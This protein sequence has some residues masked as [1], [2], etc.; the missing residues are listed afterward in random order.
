VS[1]NSLNVLTP[2]LL[3]NLSDIEYLIFN[4]MSEMISIYDTELRIQWANS[5]V[6]KSVNLDLDSIIGHYYFDIWK[7][8]KIHHGNYSLLE[9]IKTGKPQHTKII[10][11]HGQVLQIIVYPLFDDLSKIIGLLEFREDITERTRVEELHAN[12][13]ENRITE[14]QLMESEEKFRDLVEYS[15]EPIMIIN[16]QGTIL[17]ENHAIVN[18]IELEEDS[19][20]IG[21]NVIEF[22]ALEFQNVFIRDF[23][24]VSKEIDGVVSEYQFETAKRNRIYVE[25]VGKCI[26]YDGQSAKLISIHN[27]TTRIKDEEEL[28]KQNEMINRAYHELTEIEEDMRNSYREIVVKGQKLRESEERFRAIFSIVPDPIILT[29]IIDGKIVDCNPALVKLLNIPYENILGKSTIDFCIWNSQKEREKFLAEI[30]RNGVYDKREILWQ[31]NGG[32]FLNIIFSSA[33]VEIN[34]EKVILSVGFDYTNLKKAQDSL[35]ESEEMFR[36]PVENSPVGIFLFQDGFL[37]YSNKRLATM[38]GYSRDDLL[39]IPVE[40]LFSASDIQRI[41]DN[42]DK[43]ENNQPYEVRIE[44]QYAK[45]DGYSLELELYASRMQ[46]RGHPAL[47]GTI[48][49]I[50]NKKLTEKLRLAS[51]SKYRLIA[52]NMK[53]VIWILDIET[54]YFKYISPSIKHLLGYSA[55]EIEG[56]PFSDLLKPDTYNH[57]KEKFHIQLEKFLLYPYKTKFYLTKLEQQSKDGSTVLTEVV[58]NFFLNEETQKVELLGVSRDISEREKDEREIEQK[59][60]ELYRKNEE[61]YSKNE[62]LAKNQIALKFSEESLKKAQAIAHLAVWEWDV[63]NNQVYV[64]DEFNKILGRNSTESPPFYSY[65]LNSIEPQY[66]DQFDKAIKSLFE[67]GIPFT[68]DFWMIREDDGT[69]R[70]IRGQGEYNFVNEESELLT[71][72][73]QDITDQKKMEDEIREAALEKEILLR[74][75]HHRV[76]NNMQVISSLLSMQSRTIK[77]SHIQ[78]MFKETQTRVRSLA[79][80]HEFLYQSNKLDKINYNDYLHKISSYLLDLYEKP[81]G[82]L[83]LIINANNIE[84]SI[85]KA[86]PCSLIITELITN[87]LKYAFKDGRK[88]EITINLSLDPN[89]PEYS[90]V[91]RDNGLGFPPDHNLKKSSG[92]GSTLIVGLVGQLSGNIKVESENSGVYYHIIFPA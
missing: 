6:C 51:E 42:L 46:F 88:G 77:E 56:R 90:L 79:L 13:E 59:T 65:V 5:A 34:R 63:L 35:M 38:L 58:T 89:I 82:G 66:Q 2:D 74:E 14:S 20:L 44:M 22:I 84:I 12:Y 40:T 36:N 37:K 4:S 53:D 80:V 19:S 30:M 91:Y 71:I 87:S 92:F 25:I 10:T 50:T 54:W 48:I 29:S 73:L 41:R 43:S 69:K 78:S 33:I 45:A 86:V 68:L 70:A 60:L 16:K 32:D 47:Y 49:D 17:F 85:D 27:I 81:Q 83:N 18:L 1:H 23:L 72:I 61:L 8:G 39:N 62:E 31:N 24:Q 64:S 15:F 52:E 55:E 7:K 67:S 76:K 9:V 26:N 28:L 3:K 57:L 75:I 21:R 11:A